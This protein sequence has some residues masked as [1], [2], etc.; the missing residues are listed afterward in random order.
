MDFA[1][2]LEKWYE[3]HGRELPWREET[4]MRYGFRR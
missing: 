1:S 3:E 4:L 2:V